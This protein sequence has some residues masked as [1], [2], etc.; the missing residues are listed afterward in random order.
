MGGEGEYIIKG[1]NSNETNNKR[2]WKPQQKV[3]ATNVT[4]PITTTMNDVKTAS[5]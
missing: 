3:C 1:V 5:A 2:Q 4:K